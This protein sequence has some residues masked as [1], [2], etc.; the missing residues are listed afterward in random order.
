MMSINFNI[1]HYLSL[2]KIG[3]KKYVHFWC[4]VDWSIFALSWTSFALF[5]YKLTA[6]YEVLDF[7]QRTSGYA[8]KNLQIIN[9]WNK[10]LNI[11]LS[12]CTF[13]VT[14]KFMKLFRFN[15]RVYLLALT[16]S[17]CLRHLIMFGII[18]MV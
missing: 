14:L 13:L 1:L 2:V 5:I 6:A 11:C 3:F 8:Y 17:N 18:F 16:L 10:T 15:S 4:L 12:M 9:E 7:F